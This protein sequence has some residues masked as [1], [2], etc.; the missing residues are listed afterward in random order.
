MSAGNGVGPRL[1]VA[2]GASERIEVADGEADRK[3]VAVAVA[4][5]CAAP[6]RVEMS[7]RLAVRMATTETAATR[8]PEARWRAQIASILAIR[9]RVISGIFPPQWLGLQDSPWSASR[10]L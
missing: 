6:P 2:V 7:T 10:P 1:A 5:A 9:T 3:A 4:L 8:I